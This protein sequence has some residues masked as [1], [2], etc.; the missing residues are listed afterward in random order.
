MYVC[1]YVC[2]YVYIHTYIY[3][4]V[5]IYICSCV[6]IHVFICICTYSMCAYK[7]FT[8]AE[9]IAQKSI[10]KSFEGAKRHIYVDTLRVNATYI[11]IQ[12]MY[13]VFLCLHTQQRNERERIRNKT[14]RS[15]KK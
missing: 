12:C 13:E 9:S 3:V 14:Q 5:C 2:M 10:R 1:M 8:H 15:M 4:C 11:S 6:C 7:Y